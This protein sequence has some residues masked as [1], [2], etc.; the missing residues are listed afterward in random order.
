MDDS[1]ARKRFPFSKGR[2]RSGT[3]R[4]VTDGPFAETKEL[5]VG[6]WIKPDEGTS[7]DES[8]LELVTTGEFGIP[9]Q[10]AQ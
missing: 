3:R 10:P 1:M 6:S 7:E 8:E 5:I 4:T 9:G 2:G